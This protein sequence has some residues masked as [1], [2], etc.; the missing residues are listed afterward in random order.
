[1]GVKYEYKTIDMTEIAILD[2]EV[3]KNKDFNLIYKIPFR[4]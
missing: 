4:Q 2:T 1:M 3:E